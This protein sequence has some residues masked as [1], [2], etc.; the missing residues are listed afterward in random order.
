[1]QVNLKYHGQAFNSFEEMLDPAHNVAYAALL[2]KSLYRDTRS[3]SSAIQRYHSWTPRLA[4]VYH[5]KVKQAWGT[6][7][8]VAYEDRRLADHEAHQARRALKAE[9]TRLRLMAPAG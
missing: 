7:R 9:Q 5:N 4:W 8:R 3:W 1:M 2:P 6:A